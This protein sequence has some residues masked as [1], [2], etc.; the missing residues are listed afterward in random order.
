[1]D[2]VAGEFARNAVARIPEHL[3]TF[4]RRTSPRT[5]SLRTASNL[6]NAILNY[7][8][9]ILEAETRIALLAV[10]LDPGLGIVHAERRTAIHLPAMSWKRSDRT[11]MH[12]YWNYC[13]IDCS[14]P[15]TFF[16]CRDG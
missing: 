3:H 1:V 7:F 6:A 10:G 16:E 14:E 8:Y 12:S 2:T 9:A 5:S 13:E 15:A 4:G 11:S